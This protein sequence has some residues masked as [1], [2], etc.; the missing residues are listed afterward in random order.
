MRIY[1]DEEH[2]KWCAFWAANREY[3]TYYNSQWGNVV[4]KDHN[5]LNRSLYSEKFYN[6]DKATEYL[7]EKLEQIRNITDHIKDL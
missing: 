5:F 7:N 1:A 3:I 4:E 6:L 2:K